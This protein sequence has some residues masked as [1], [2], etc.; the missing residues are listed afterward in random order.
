ML[1]G[2]PE[3][4][5]FIKS[6]VEHLSVDEN[7]DRVSVVQFADN[8]EVN[9]DLNSYKAK[10]DT[11]N[12]IDNLRHKG[13]RRLDIGGALQFVR[14]SV[15]TSSTG[16]RRLEGVPQILILLS[17]KPST[18]NVRSPAFALKEHDIVSV[19]V[20]VGDAK[21][22]ELEMIAFKPG[23]A[24]KVTDFS[25]LPSIQSQLVATLNINRDTEETM[26]GISDLVGSNKRDIVFLLDGSDDSRN[27]LPAIREFIR[28]MVEEL[29]IDEDKVRVAVVQY[30]DDTR[31]YFNLK[32]HR[33]KK[34]II[35]AVRSLR[36]KGGRPRNTG[37][38][39]QF[40]RD[41]VFTASSGSRR[42][43][44]V[45][46]I[47]FLLTGGKSADDVSGPAI[48]LK[49]IGILSF[50]I[51]MKSTEQQ[52]LQ[53]IAFS[54]R[55]LFNLPVFGE[56]L[57][58]QPE[59]AAF[60]RAEIQTEPP[61]VVVELDS[62]Q[63]D[64]VFLLDGSDDTRSGFPAMKSFVQRV[65]D[66]LSVGENK[67]RVSV[68]QYSRDPQTHFNLNTYT[69][70]QDV[71]A[72]V[73]QLNHKGGKPLNTGAALNYVRNNAFTDSSGSRHQEGVPQILILLSGG[74]SQD[75]VAGA[76]AALK[77][78]KVVAFCVDEM[79]N[80]FNA[81]RGFVGRMVEK[82]TVDENKDRVSVLQY[83][84]EPS[85]EFF[86]NTHKTQQNV[87]D[88]VGVLRHKGGTR[89]NTGAALQYVKDNVFTAS[90]GSR[91][92]QGVPQIL[93]LLTGG[94]STDDVKNAVENLKGIG[95]MVFVVGTRNADTLEIQS[96]SQEAS[97][98]FFAADPSDL[99]DIEQQILSAI[100]MGET[101]AIKPVL[102]D[103]NRRDVV[104]LLDGSDDSQQKFPDITD[105]VQRIVADLNIDTNKDHVAVVQYSNTAETDFNL[106]RYSTKDEILDAVR[107]L[108]HKGGYPHNIGAAL[109]YV[110]DHVF[111]S[112][113]GSRL[114]EGVPQILI[115]LSGG[116]SGD[117]IRT[118]VRMLKEIGVISIAIGTTEAD[119][120]ELQTI[121]HEPNYA[122]SV[123]DY[124]KLPT[125]K[126]DVFLLLRQAPHHVEQ[127]T[128]TD[129]LDSKKQDVVFLIDGSYDSR[130]GFEG[131][132]GFL[133]K[134]VE[135]LSLDENRDQ[136]AVVQYSRDATANF[137]LNSYSSKTDVLNAIG[138][139]R[140]KLGRPLNVGK[141]LEFVRDNV[142]ASSVGGRLDSGKKDIVF[143]LDGSDGTRNGF[144]AMREFVERVVEKLNV[145]QNNDRVSV[146]QYS[147]D[148]EVNFYL[149][150][151]STKEDIVDSVRG[152]RH[153]GGRPLNTGAALQYVRDNVFTPSSGSRRLQGVPQMLIL[154]LRHKGGRPLNTGAALQYLR[155]NVF[156]AS[157]GS[158]RLEGVPQVLI[159]LS[160]GRSSDS[161][162]APAS[163]LKQLGVLI[164]AIGS[165]S[166]D[167]RELETISHDPTSALSKKDI[168]FLLD[169]SDGT[170]NGFPA[171]R[172]FV[173]RVVEKLNV[174]Q[175]NDRVSV[176]QYSRDP[177][178]NF[179]L[180]TH[181]TKEDIVDS[182]RGLRHKG[183]R[184]LNTGAALQYVRD[185]VFTN[186]SG[187]RRLQGVP[188][189]LILLNGGRSFDNVD[190][191][192][193]ALK[194]QGIFVIGIG[195]RN[196]DRSELQ[197]ISY[198]PSY[199]LSRVVETLS[200]DDNKDRVS[201]VQYSRDPAVQ[202]YLNTYSTKAVILDT[203]RGLRHKGGRPLNTGA[204]LQ[205][206]RDNVFTASAGS[207]RLEG[208]P[209][210]LIVLSGGRSSDSVDAPASALKQLGVLIF[211]IGSRSSDSREL[212]TISHDPTSALSC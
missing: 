156:T 200:L 211:A 50:A 110:R 125:A 185:N 74:R 187:S 105:F 104:F 117:D 102:H 72:A 138:T 127:T 2:F 93:V 28:R 177:E 8:P 34:A 205:Y 199:A 45:P 40:V 36:H 116:R 81:V 46:Q 77:Q 165:R 192:A 212:E 27:G 193:A 1:N 43:E 20:G 64:I 82:L 106:R 195:T 57:S 53:K 11:L 99:P 84:R 124:E 63:R 92:Q 130:N 60:V 101:P 174:G 86:L 41:H 80:D 68:V 91:L 55:F 17:S 47:L 206:L 131:I 146:V 70:K 31:V 208:V 78:D 123:T 108:R 94:R 129:G 32:T 59:I 182:V 67:D 144:P 121:S 161:V 75:D 145:G 178:V 38:A 6:I 132:R 158:R 35:Y 79:R 139:M 126:Q 19:G 62:P 109:Q 13:G 198:E 69:E 180:N 163:A 114:L 169:G 97:H 179:Y 140:H 15:F 118:P 152:L 87:A 10:K 88:S 61:T 168:V 52:E 44:G 166:S 137:Y 190:S 58:I 9:F 76:A 210:V 136:V 30:S 150:T 65:V 73:K 42:L 66:T 16:S 173:E 95:V 49:Q 112:E 142:F 167:S 203:V 89:R 148:P 22:S 56:L 164:F 7:Q 162:D 197:K 39:L 149:N 157:A 90:S 48:N 98:A 201:V 71:L 83:S 24:Y 155:D 103:P 5:L 189:M 175:N 209:Q 171:M 23:F 26:T 143:L 107:G 184:P 25:K 191:P 119:T 186:S 29:D 111:T 96:M 151:H 21:L 181:S 51:G 54:S 183:G 122:L 153:K 33:S 194:Q 154:G 176:V 204:A 135:S 113:S 172:E 141:A 18:D 14:H 120:L 159:V 188:Q 128:P 196:S 4:K 207:R 115:L 134:F 12:A 160:G 100:V 147:R 37:A 170:R 202:F 85:V 133:K 3:I